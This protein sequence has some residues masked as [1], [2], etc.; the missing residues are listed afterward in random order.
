YG[1]DGDGD[2]IEDPLDAMQLHVAGAFGNFGMQVAYQEEFA[3]A[4]AIFGVSGSTAFAGADVQVSFID[5]GSEN[6]LGLGASYPVGPVVVGGYYS[7]NDVAENNYG[8]SADYASGAFAVAAAYDVDAGEAGADDVGTY[9]ID[10]SYDVGNGLM[11]FGGLVGNDVDGDD[12]GYYAAATYDLGGGAELLFSYADDG[13]DTNYDDEF[14][15]PE[16]MEGTTV[17]V[18][19]SF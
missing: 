5:D 10:A 17:E 2:T 9:E 7:I 1:V 12:L 11:L 6:S 14:G 18:S 4:D 13:D 19:F 8:V 3:G 15:G 16:Y